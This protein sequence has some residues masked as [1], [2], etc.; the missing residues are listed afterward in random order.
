MHLAGSE[1][2]WLITRKSPIGRKL[3]EAVRHA[4]QERKEWTT[5]LCLLEFVLLSRLV[6]SSYLGHNSASLQVCEGCDKGLQ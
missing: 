1:A 2:S 3:A 4:V 5:G 6:R